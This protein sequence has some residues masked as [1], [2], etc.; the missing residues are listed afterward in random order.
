MN[1]EYILGRV[2]IV[3][4]CYNA[5]KFISKQLESILLQDYSDIELI[6]FDDGSQDGTSHIV[7][8]YIPKFIKRGWSAKLIQ[9]NNAGQS[10]VINTGLS[11]ITGEYFVWPDADDFYNSSEAVSKMVHAFEG[12]DDDVAVVRTH[13][14]VLTA[15]GIKVCVRGGNN[16]GRESGRS[17]F[18]DCLY[19]RNGFYFCSGAYMICTAHFFK[20]SQYPIYTSK[21][22]GQNWQLLLP[23]L[24]HY[25]C[26]TLPET[27]YS[28]VEHSDSHGR[29]DHGYNGNIRRIDCYED[30]ILE[31]LS[32]IKGMPLQEVKSFSN[33]IRLKYANARFWEAR[34]H[35]IKGEMVKYYKMFVAYGGR[36]SHMHILSI[37]ARV[38][39]L[40]LLDF[41]K[42]RLK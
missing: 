35:K 42:G 40:N 10:N 21:G 9:Q 5:E 14:N 33:N 15:N 23:L 22:A 38:G 29:S 25:D 34:R 4:P 39:M 1:R 28:I 12:L 20:V 8:S 19:A 30:T 18:E 11:L 32:R 7:D 3:I 24:Y 13:N 6:V 27:L 41:I 37:S 26:Y 31:T 2:S 17:L 16:M 36:S